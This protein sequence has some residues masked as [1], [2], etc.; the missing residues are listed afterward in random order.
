MDKLDH[1]TL[2]Q[3][4]EKAKASDAAFRFCHARRGDGQRAARAADV[5]ALYMIW[6]AAIRRHRNLAEYPLDVFR[7]R[8]GNQVLPDTFAARLGPR[9]RLGCPISSIEHGRSGVTVHYTELDDKKS[10]QAEYLVCAL[11]MGKLKD[12]PVHPLAQGERVRHSQRRVQHADAYRLPVSIAVLEK[13]PAQ[14]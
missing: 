8:G 2:G 6:Q 12:L 10:L 4:L 1:E 13:R 5:S 3:V 11:P 14:R 7:L 9:L